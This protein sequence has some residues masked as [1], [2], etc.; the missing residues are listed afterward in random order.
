MN[1]TQM[2]IRSR[3]KSWGMIVCVTAA[4]LV[5]GV[6]PATSR[7]SAKSKPANPQWI[8][9]WATAVPSHPVRRSSL[10]AIKLSVLSCTPASVALK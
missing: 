6:I 10:T 2:E 4:L 9:T 1:Q 7:S 8:G 5:L 3:Q